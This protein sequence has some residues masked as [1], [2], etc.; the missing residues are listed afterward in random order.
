MILLL[1]SID[2]MGK[3]VRGALRDALMVGCDSEHARLRL[4][5]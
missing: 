3:G 5:K 4:R 1:R 2:W